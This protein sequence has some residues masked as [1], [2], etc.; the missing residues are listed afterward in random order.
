MATG[1]TI[2]CAETSEGL[3]PAFGFSE[4]L[5]AIALDGSLVSV[6]GEQVFSLDSTNM[7]PHC[8]MELA[9][10]ITARYDEFDGFVIAH[11]TDTLGYAAAALSCLIQNSVKPVVLTG[12]MLPMAA[13]DSDAPRNLRHAFIYAAAEGAFGVKVVFGGNIYDGRSVSKIRTDGFDAFDSIN[14]EKCGYFDGNSAVFTEKYQ[15]EAKF[16]DRLDEGVYVAALTPGQELRVP[17]FDGLRAVIVKGYGDGGVPEYCEREIAALCGEGIYVII[18]T[19][20]LYG[21]TNLRL[22]RVGR[23]AA[24]R[25]PLLE[26]GQMTTEY[27]VARAQWALA[28]SRDPD[29]FER[30]FSGGNAGAF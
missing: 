3:A 28:Y 29:E 24:E 16:F 7:T 23:A 25:Y 13:L 19:Q 6:T 5:S 1:G 8:W 11:G 22:Y 18:S 21:G 9:K 10:R 4:L 17:R 30:L 2:S 12:S 26:T 15:G 20:A 27:A 14:H